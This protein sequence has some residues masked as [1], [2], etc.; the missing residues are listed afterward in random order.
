MRALDPDKRLSP[1]K[2]RELYWNVVF[3]LKSI[4]P[5][6]EDKLLD[7]DIKDKTARVEKDFTP[8]VWKKLPSIVQSAVVEWILQGWFE[9]I[10]E[11]NRTYEG[12]GMA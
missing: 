9:W 2:L 10:A 1:R 8:K 4:T 12:R 11:S 3:G 5:P 6:Q 7:L